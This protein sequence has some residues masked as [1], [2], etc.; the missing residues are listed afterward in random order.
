MNAE[1]LKKANELK[2]QI[3]K[4]ESWIKAINSATIADTP[5]KIHLSY[6]TKHIVEPTIS[7]MEYARKLLPII[8]KKMESDLEELKR[9]F[10]KL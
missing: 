5:P 4:L 2:E 8:V 10:E 3:D 7:D 6:Y 1:T 9:E